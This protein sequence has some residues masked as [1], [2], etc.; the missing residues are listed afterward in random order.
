MCNLESLC[1]VH[2][3]GTILH[4]VSIHPEVHGYQNNVGETLKYRVVKNSWQ[5]A[6]SPPTSYFW[7]ATLLGYSSDF[8]VKDGRIIHLL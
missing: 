7:P 2:G 3:Q 1:Y 5:P 4:S 8:F 6:K